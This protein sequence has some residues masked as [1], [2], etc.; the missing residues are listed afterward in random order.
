LLRDRLFV[1]VV[2]VGETE[3]MPTSMSVRI[4][5]HTNAGESE[6]VEEL[7]RCEVVQVHHSLAL[8]RIL[9]LL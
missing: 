7:G 5:F 6:G 1:S 9:C 2:I 8:S 4:G 3:S